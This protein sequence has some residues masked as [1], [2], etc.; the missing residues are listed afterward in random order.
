MVGAITTASASAKTLRL[1]L[2]Y[3]IFV[4]PITCYIASVVRDKPTN[5]LASGF[6]NAI[7]KLMKTNPYDE[8][9]IALLY[10][11]KINLF[12]IIS[13]GIFKGCMK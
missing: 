7:F 3:L 12:L 6:L 10:R 9:Y 4:S 8:L 11:D 2:R 5:N 1:L 13:L